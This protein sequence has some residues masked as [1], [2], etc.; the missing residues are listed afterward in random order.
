MLPLSSYLLLVAIVKKLSFLVTVFLFPC[1]LGFDGSNYVFQIY[2][3]SSGF[4]F[5]YRFRIRLGF[6]NKFDFS[7]WGLASQNVFGERGK[8][9]QHGWANRLHRV[10]LLWCLLVVKLLGLGSGENHIWNVTHHPI[11]N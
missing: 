2:S 1:L 4:R 10:T 6:L 7:C 5:G 8:C 3:G 11:L 9:L